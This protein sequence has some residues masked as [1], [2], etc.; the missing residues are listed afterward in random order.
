MLK[1][2]ETLLKIRK[3]IRPI[4]VHSTSAGFYFEVFGIS[5]YQVTLWKTDANAFFLNNFLDGLDGDSDDRHAKGVAAHRRGGGMRNDTDA[6]N[7]DNGRQKS[8]S[9]VYIGTSTRYP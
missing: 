1:T 3:K 2:A 5:F 7:A 6:L 4:A 9:T 8:I